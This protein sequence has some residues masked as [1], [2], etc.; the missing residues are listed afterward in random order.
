MHIEYSI[1]SRPSYYDDIHCRNEMESVS[2]W[3]ESAINE[4]SL[5]SKIKKLSALIS[6]I[7]EQ[8]LEVNPSK[9]GEVAFA[10]ECEGRE[11]K[12]IGGDRA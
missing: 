6:V 4:G 11:H 7:G 10:I 2:Y 12:I 1:S 5:E 8:Y 9:V 3:I